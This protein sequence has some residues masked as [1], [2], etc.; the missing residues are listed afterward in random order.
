MAAGG[1]VRVIVLAFFA[2]L[3]IAIAKLVAAIVTRSGSMMAESIHSF[4]DAGNQLLLLLGDKRAKKP[5][6]EQHPLG[7]GREAYFWALLVAVMLFVL[8]GAYSLYEGIHKMKDPH[9]INQPGWAI[10]VLTLGMLL[11]GYSLKAAWDEGKRRRGST[12]LYA[13]AR[14]TGNVN[15]LVVLFEDIAAMAGLVLAFI[16]VGLTWITGDP[17]F[18][19]LGSCVIGVLLLYVAVFLVVQVRRLIVGFTAGPEIRAGMTAIWERHGF[20]VVHLAAL[21]SGPDRLF[22]VGK[23]KPRD[24]SIPAGRLV[25][26]LD[27]ADKEVY[28][29]YP[30]VRFHFVEPDFDADGF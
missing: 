20:E 7:Y 2:N 12:P 10:G 6:D 5:A 27:E 29:A 30:E 14:T 4:A 22:V 1:S 13:W 23:V 16:A 19:A 28:R 25:E 11:E 17:L 8:G 9:P 24:T 21:W 18:D 26:I 15:L 3:G